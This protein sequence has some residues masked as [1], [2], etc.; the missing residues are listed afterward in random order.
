MRHRSFYLQTLVPQSIRS[1]YSQ[2]EIVFNLRAAT[3]LIWLKDCSIY[4]SSKLIVA[5][6]QHHLHNNNTA[7]NMITS[8]KIYITSTKPS[9]QQL[10]HQEHDHIQKNIYYLNNNTTKNRITSRK[11]YIT[12]TLPSQQQHRQEHDHI[13]KNIYDL[14]RRAS[15][16]VK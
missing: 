10:H 7:K 4:C 16:V 13:Q 12:S 11:I 2:V 1:W 8:R 3:S 14:K 6:P 15:P 5:I 9:Q